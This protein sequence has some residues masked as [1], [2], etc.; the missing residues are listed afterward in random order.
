MTTRSAHTSD[1]SDDETEEYNEDFEES[2]A[3]PSSSDAEPETHL[4]NSDSVKSSMFLRIGSPLA[5]E[6]RSPSELSRMST[7]EEDDKVPLPNLRFFD[8]SAVL[9]NRTYAF[10][11]EGDGAVEIE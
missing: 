2:D 1:G 8:L 11:F 10:Y 5:W 3:P 7:E 9:R 6:G 4:Y